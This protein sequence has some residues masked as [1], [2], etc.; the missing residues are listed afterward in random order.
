MQGHLAWLSMSK[1]YTGGFIYDGVAYDWQ[2]DKESLMSIKE[3][4][5]LKEDDVVIATYP[6]CGTW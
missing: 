1:L 5:T 3:S 6:K 4:L 2:H